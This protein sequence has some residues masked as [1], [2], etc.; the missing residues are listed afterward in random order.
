[1]VLPVFDTCGRGALGADVL[2][3]CVMV[4]GSSTVRASYRTPA[5]PASS[6]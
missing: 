3:E 4:W 6:N 5:S 1:M 2:S